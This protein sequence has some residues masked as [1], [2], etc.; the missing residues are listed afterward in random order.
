MTYAPSNIRSDRGSAPLLSSV[1]KRFAATVFLISAATLAF[2][3]AAQDA[4]DQFLNT[5][6]PVPAPPPMIQPLSV[7]P[8]RAT[9]PLSNAINLWRSLQQSDNYSFSSYANFLVAHPGWPNEAVFR[10][11]AERMIRADSEAP[12]SVIAF[13]TKFPPLTAAAQLR[14][15][16]ALDSAGQRAEAFAAARQ[17]WISGALTPED[18]A[19]FLSRYTSALQPG[20]QDRRMDQLL[21]SRST[22][23]AARQ[24]AA[25]SGDKRA[26]FNARLGFLI[27]APDVAERESLVASNQRNDAG[28]VADRV[29]WLRA[30]GR[31]DEANAFLSQP[32]KFDTAPLDPA[33]WLEILEATARTAASNEQHS[34][35]VA[36]AR[37]LEVTYP[38][39]V[40][41]RNRPFAERDRYTNIA[42][43]GGTTALNKLGRPADA[44]RL[45]ELYAQAARSAQ[46]RAKGHYW[47]GRAAEQAGRR[48]VAT[49]HYTA[50]S[51]FFDQFH[52]QLAHEK[53]GRTVQL[54]LDPTTIEISASERQAFER[55]EVVR[56]VILLGQ[57][58]NHEEQTKFVRTL[59]NSVEGAANHALAGELA[60]RVNRQDLGLLVGKSAREDGFP[61]YFKPSFP[62]L[63]VPAEHMAAWTMIHAVTRQESQFDRQAMSR[64]GARGLMQLMPATA[65]QTAP[66]AGV[67][68]S[69]SGLTQNPQD[70][71]RLG[72]TYFGQLMTEFGGSYVL[73]AAAYNAGPG[74]VR[75][76]LRANGDPRL[77]G[78][79]VMAWIEAIP[80][81]ETRGY[82]QHILENA[83]VYDMLNPNR[84]NRPPTKLT[85]FLGRN[86]ATYGSR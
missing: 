50:A 51:E 24:I 78:T 11:N 73:S 15:A 80:L 29:F 46:T 40:L 18:E 85:A 27:K 83:V 41:V 23:A 14:F 62:V 68:Y 3:A 22:A 76:W 55:N 9:D 82:V 4:P 74:N 25:V 13:F 16:E 17:A 53:L 2:P 37:Q 43:L 20:D 31:V 49:L 71:I 39:G 8:I 36:I 34:A 10:K 35:A 84:G 70:N 38:S 57:Q 60:N 19:R 26:I 12:K 69:L 7:Q 65:K 32:R 59:A 45:F 63:Q 56:A 64:V 79:D 54:P 44:I 72:A 5:V 30:S 77:S 66:A 75:K 86:Q 6:L 21:W 52:G 47:A 48:D 28:Y 67:S 33:K 81:T 61:G 58:G 42:W 1:S